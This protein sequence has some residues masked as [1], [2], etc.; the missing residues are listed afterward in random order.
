MRTALT[1]ALLAATLCARSQDWGQRWI[2]HPAAEPTEQVWFRHTFLVDELPASA[3]V[4]VAS[5]GLYALFVNGYN[6]TTDVLEPL[7]AAAPGRVTVTEYEVARF[8]RSDTN[9]VAVWYSPLS[10]TRK[11]LSLSLYAPGRRGSCLAFAADGTWMCRTAGAVTTPGGAETMADGDF[12]EDWNR[13]EASLLD[14]THAAEQRGMPPSRMV[15]Q[16]HLRRA[17]RVAVTDTYSYFDDHG[18]DLVYRFS[19]PSCGWVRVT[20]RGMSRGDTLRVGGLTYICSGR[21]DE[22]ACRRFTTELSASVLISGPPGFSRDNIMN[23]E[24]I[25]IEPYVRMSYAY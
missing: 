9:V 3:R 20:L 23:V 19:R 5:G 25:G 17:M 7:P 6:V 16:G 15:W 24:A 11:Q 4:T 2:A 22:Q 12:R 18:S 13:P 21:T 14:W 1:I 8:L 10:P